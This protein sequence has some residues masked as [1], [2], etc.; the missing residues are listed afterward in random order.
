M[1]LSG[2]GKRGSD[3]RKDVEGGCI[4]KGKD[5]RKG[6]GLTHHNEVSGGEEARD[7]TGKKTRGRRGKVGDLPIE[8]GKKR[9]GSS[10]LPFC[11]TFL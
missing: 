7:E 5:E 9:G 11:S 6:A 1:R 2:N 10:S 8:K 3:V 4:K